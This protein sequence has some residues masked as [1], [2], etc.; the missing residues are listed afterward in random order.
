VIKW[1]VLI[2]AVVGLDQF[3]KYWVL[4]NVA[5]GVH[6]PVTDF[7]DLVLVFNP[8]AA[9]SFLADQPGWQRWFFVALAAVVVSW[10][11]AL[12]WRH[13][14]ELLLPLSMSFVIG[15][16]IGNVTDRLLHGAVVDFL[17]FHLGGHYW[18]AFNLADSAITLGVAL[19]LWSQFRLHHHA[20]TSPSKLP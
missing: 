1:L 2:L 17:Y 5:E 15:G 6:V 4:G 14:R 10:L 19:L 7:F 9:F 16:A 20:T 13:R 11:G 12:L 18:P 3:S 8:G